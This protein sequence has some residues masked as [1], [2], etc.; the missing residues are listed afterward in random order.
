MTGGKAPVKFQYSE[1]ID[2]L[3]IQLAKEIGVS[4]VATSYQCDPEV[5]DG[6]IV[7]DFDH[8]HRVIGIEILHA[9]DL[10]P[11]EFMTHVKSSLDWSPNNNRD[12]GGKSD[13]SSRTDE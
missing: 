5:V 11:E 2:A 4:G 12:S 8:R 3:Y 13:S 6:I 7:L 10:L 9:T 1:D